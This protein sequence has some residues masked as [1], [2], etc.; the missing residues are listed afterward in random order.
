M[1]EVYNNFDFVHTNY[2]FRLI[3]GRYVTAR[4]KYVKKD[5]I[6]SRIDFS[7]GNVKQTWR[8]LNILM[9]RNSKSSEITSVKSGDIDISDPNV[10]R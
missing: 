6:Q 3:K 5:Y 4:L 9:S 10:K 2:A 8:H 1:F 7:K